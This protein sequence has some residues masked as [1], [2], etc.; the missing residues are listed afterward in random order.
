MVFIKKLNRLGSKKNC[1]FTAFILF[2]F[3]INLFASEN[4]VNF[5]GLMHFWYSVG[6]GS[7]ASGYLSG[8]NVRR[9]RLKAYGSLSGNTKWY[10]QFAYDK[11]IPKLLDA[12][13]DIGFSEK[14]NFRIGQQVVPGP[15]S[16]SVTS[17]AELE[18][19]ERAQFVQKWGSF[20][21]LLSYRTVG[22]KIFGS[23]LN[24]RLFYSAMIGNPASENLFKP[25]IASSYTSYEN[26]NLLM[27]GRIE[28]E[29]IMGMKIG[30][31]GSVLPYDGEVDAFSFGGHLL[32]ES[33]RIYT[34]AEVLMGEDESK[35]EYSGAQAVFGYKF[36]N[37][38]PI[39]RYDFYIP[40][41]GNADLAGVKQYNNFTFG[42]NYWISEDVKIL[43]NYVLRSEEMLGN[44]KQIDNDIFYINLQTTF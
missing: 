3:A 18:F 42:V 6:E 32:Y 24:E 10:V 37:L 28:V 9:V 1:Y 27:I 12:A 44:I 34:K 35:L 16:S 33:D 30:C 7:N 38:Q 4:N 21:N 29:P 36:N 41:G 40:N 22:V 19:V 23:A 13:L 11:Q 17:T 26:A 5:K 15:I 43:V 25:S 39:V 2:F 31:F 14:A 20:S 8:F